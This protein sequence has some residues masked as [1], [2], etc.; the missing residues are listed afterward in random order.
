LHSA[1]SNF[2]VITMLGGLYA[3]Y[4]NKEKMGKPH[5]T[6]WHS[7]M[8]IFAMALWVANVAV[9]AAHTADLEKK[10]LVFLWKSRNHRWLGKAAFCAGLGATVLGL[11]SGWGVRSL[12]GE[13]GAWALTLGVLGVF[14]G[15]VAAREEGKVPKAKA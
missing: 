15:I 7:W 2:A 4:S 12:G 9:A 3:I 8:G 10:R 1:L 6:S 14:V 5:W 13:Q 11:H